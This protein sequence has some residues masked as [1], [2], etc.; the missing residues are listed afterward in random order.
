VI[1]VAIEDF[2]AFC[3]VHGQGYRPCVDAALGA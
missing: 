3:C 2:L 1:A